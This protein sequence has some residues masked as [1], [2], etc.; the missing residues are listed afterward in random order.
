[1]ISIFIYRSFFGP[2]IVG[3]GAETFAQDLDT[4]L[5]NVVWEPTWHEMQSKPTRGWL[6]SPHFIFYFLGKIIGYDTSTLIKL[7]YIFFCALSGFAIFVLCKYLLKLSGVYINIEITCFLAGLLYLL[8]LSF[9]L[10]DAS[11][12]GMQFA[13]SVF[14]LIIY[15]FFKALYEK[16]YS[17]ALICGFL[18]VNAAA[19]DQRWV[20]APLIIIFPYVIIKSVIFNDLKKSMLNFLTNLKYLLFAILIFILLGGYFFFQIVSTVTVGKVTALTKEAVDATWSNANLV[21]LIRASAHFEL[22]KYIANVSPSILQYYIIPSGLLLVAL[23]LT[24]PLLKN[25]EKIPITYS[26]FLFLYILLVGFFAGFDNLSREALYWLVLESPYNHFIGR[27]FRT[28]RIP[29]L[30]IATCI[31][32]LLTFS[33]NLILTKIGDKGCKRIL[34]YF[35]VFVTLILILLASV[36]LLTGDVAGRLH[37]IQIPNEYKRTNEF[38][39]RQ[40]E[41]FKVVWTPEFWGSFQPSWS[42][43]VPMDALTYYGSSKPVY[44]ARNNIFVHYYAYTVFFRFRSLLIKGQIEDLCNFLKPLNIKY[45]ILHNDIRQ[46]RNKFANVLNSTSRSFCLRFVQK[47]GEIYIFEVENYSKP[48]SISSYGAL[49]YGGLETSKKIVTFVPPI[50]SDQL[51]DSSTK[52]LEFPYISIIVLSPSKNINDLLMP[53][54]IIIEPAHYSI[55]YQ[56]DKWSRAYITDPHHGSWNDFINQFY[57]QKWEFGYGIPTGFVFIKG[58]KDILKIPIK[59]EKDDNYYIFIRLLKN[60]KGGKIKISLANI[61]KTIN[62]KDEIKAEFVWI[63]IGELNLIKGKYTLTIENIKGYNAINILALIP[64]KEYYKAEKEVK[65]LLQ[66]K[67]IIYLFEAE[68]DLYRLDAKVV[69][70]FNFSNGEALALFGKAWQDVEIVK[71]GT[72]RLALK[73][74][75]KFRVK[76]NSNEFELESKLNFSYTPMFFLPSGKYRLEITPIVEN[77]VRNP[78]FEGVFD[79]LPKGWKIGNT[80]NFKISFDRGPGGKYG[81]KVLTSA[82]KKGTWS[83]I[84]SEPIDVEPEKE[85]LIITHAKGE[86]AK[87]SHILIE[88][89]FADKKLWKQLRQILPG[90]KGIRTYDWKEFSYI[91]KIPKNVTKIRVVLNVGWVLDDSKDE[92]MT[93]FDDMQVVSL[94]DV[95]KLDVI[96]LYSTETNQ[97]IDQLFEVK[98]RPAEVINYTKINPTLWKVKVSA[99]K[100][101]ML[102][103][104]EA[105]D[106][107]WEARVYK[108]GKKVEVIKSVPLYS[109]ING[110]WINATGDLTIVIRYVPQDW[111]ELGLKI[112][113]TTFIL[114]IFYLIWDWRRSRGDRW[115]VGLEKVFRR[116]LTSAR[117]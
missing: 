41:D 76:I 72:Y 12:I 51:K 14:P 84:R 58:C 110:F 15:F 60:P 45:I 63:K 48:V 88:G 109:V 25:D 29:D 13:F 95:P 61:S 116:A 101:F 57:Y 47:F 93:W 75:G 56:G 117:K 113:A 50:F 112:S 94:S 115:T 44:F 9:R 40:K 107:L 77:L 66:N 16:K 80:K 65:K 35:I 83:R 100:P 64:E 36:P 26:Y 24:L 32:I 3:H 92:A 21:N 23:S 34:K 18:W 62:T 53:R 7:E 4:F 2:G 67:T 85:Y 98:E 106:P 11:Y 37:P 104:A 111:F 81:L 39:I 22:P 96:W 108:N 6:Y 28:T 38:L 17:Y 69:K 97:T 90:V 73:G 99:T 33:L 27:L 54:G 89:Y 19:F 46:F 114:C 78:S 49:V 105:Y 59:I 10:G 87:A 68:S 8:N 79:G 91:F 86:K 103:F 71:S 74:K 31:S 42:K 1:M 55:Y 20:I 30:I 82:T 102:S 70:D 52:K 43:G 5:K